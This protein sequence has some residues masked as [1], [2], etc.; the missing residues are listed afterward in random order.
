MAAISV[1]L[2]S[3]LR[4]RIGQKRVKVDIPSPSTA[5]AVLDALVESYPLM[6][7]F[8]PVMRL[9]VNQVYANES[10]TVVEGDEVA[11]ITPVS[12]G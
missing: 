10:D 5:A 4:Q 6:E 3:V 2:F 9:A 12:G 11:V 7:P 8:R 1:F